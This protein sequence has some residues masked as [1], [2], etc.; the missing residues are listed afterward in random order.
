MDASQEQTINAIIHEYLAQSKY[1]LAL[2]AFEK[3]SESKG[4]AISS[5]SNQQMN[6]DRIASIQVSNGN[7]SYYNG[8]ESHKSAEPIPVGNER[9]RSRVLLLAL[10]QPF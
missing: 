3:E 7:Q 6:Q 1:P 4:L 8:T 10:G 2:D 9:R 5:N